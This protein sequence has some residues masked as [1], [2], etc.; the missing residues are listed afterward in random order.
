MRIL[1]VTHGYPPARVGGVEI[2]AEQLARALAKD[3]DVGVLYPTMDDALDP[4]TWRA[5][6]VDGVEHFEARVERD[7]IR[8]ENVYWNA[9]IDAMFERLVNEWK[10]DVVHVHSLVFL[11]FGIFDVTRRR[12]LPTVMNLHDFFSVC[13]LGQ[14]IRKDLD[15]CETVD[16]ERCARCLRPDWRVAWERPLAERPVALARAAAYRVFKS[17]SVA[18]LERQDERMRATLRAVDVVIAPSEF[19]RRQFVDYG[20]DPERMRTVAIGVERDDLRVVAERVASE[21][22]ESAAK[23]RGLRFGYL[24]S[25]MPTKGAHVLLEAFRGIDR[26]GSTLDIHGEAAPFH[27]DDSYGRNLAERIRETPGATLHGRYD[28]SQLAGILD[29]M[30]V[31]VVP[32]I[33]YET[34]CITIREGFLANVP[35]IASRLG[36]MAEAIEDGETGLSFRAGDA[37]D[38]RDAMRRLVDDPTLRRRLALSPK[39]VVSVDDNAAVYGEIYAGL[40]EGAPPRVGSDGADA[41]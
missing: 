32:S 23:V 26:P 21:T 30:D 40:V 25:V 29:R 41:N 14:R 31:L 18:R 3:H 34:F 37:T 5:K 28:T 8:F 19:Q 6:D 36:P 7:G 1:Y 2:H 13:P 10:P 15:L 39:G 27:G 38:L 20:L 35:V 9:K 16:R 11:S 24:G 33:W 4:F 12:G 22:A 17:P